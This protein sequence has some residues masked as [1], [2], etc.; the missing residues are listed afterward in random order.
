MKCPFF[1]SSLSRFASQRSPK[2]YLQFIFIIL[3]AV[4]IRRALKKNNFLTTVPPKLAADCLKEKCTAY[5]QCLNG[6][7]IIDS[8]R[9]NS[10]QVMRDR[11]KTAIVAKQNDGPEAKGEPPIA[12]V[13]DNLIKESAIP[14]K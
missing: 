1:I 11:F 9:P 8:R 3:A 13:I 6:H 2:E 4:I 7:R 10:C 12:E 5:R 14:K